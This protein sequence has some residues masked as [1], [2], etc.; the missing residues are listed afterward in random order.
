V[1]HDGAL[2]TAGELRAALDGGLSPNAATSEG[3][4]LL[5][6]ASADIE[7]VRLLVDRGADV[8]R[9]AKTG[10][11]P[12]MVALNR[13]GAS[14]SRAAAPRS[15]ARVSLPIRSPCT[16]HHRCSMPSGPATSTRRACSSSVAPA[17]ACR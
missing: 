7:K 2:R 5:M 3:T 12:L 11:T 9:A 17:R 8:N 10:F 16:A 14:P 15:G 4:T 13:R 1:D 6:M